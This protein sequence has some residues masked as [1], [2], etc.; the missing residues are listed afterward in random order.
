MGFLVVLISVEVQLRCTCFKFAFELQIHVIR[1]S[2]FLFTT[3]FKFLARVI[4][5]LL[6]TTQCVIFFLTPVV[7]PFFSALPIQHSLQTN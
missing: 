7:N 6:L 4:F 2:P 1:Y 5:K 3:L